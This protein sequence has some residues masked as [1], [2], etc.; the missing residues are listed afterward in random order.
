MMSIQISKYT[1]MD[2]SKTKLCAK[3]CF[4]FGEISEFRSFSMENMFPI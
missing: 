4:Y 3:E 1:L 2:I